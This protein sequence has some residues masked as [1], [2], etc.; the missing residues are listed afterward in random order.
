[1]EYKKIKGEL[2]DNFRLGTNALYKLSEFITVKDVFGNEV[3]PFKY[4]F[5]SDA[6]THIERLVFA[7]RITD[8]MTDEDVINNV[9][10]SLKVDFRQIE[11]TLTMMIHGGDYETIEPAENYLQRLLSK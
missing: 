5:V 2:T 7:A 1:M 10:G 9:K 8:G 4:V 3:E 6:S 11:G